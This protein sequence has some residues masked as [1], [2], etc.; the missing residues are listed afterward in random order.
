MRKL[1]AERDQQSA[2][3]H[4]DVHGHAATDYHADTDRDPYRHAD[5][6]HYVD[7][8]LDGNPDPAPRDRVVRHFRLTGGRIW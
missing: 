6:D 3:P 8:Y 1:R 7:R 5:N 2:Q 4:R